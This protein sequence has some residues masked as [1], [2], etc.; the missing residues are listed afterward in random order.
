MVAQRELLGTHSSHI[1]GVDGR[2]VLSRP[3]DWKGLILERKE[4]PVRA[5]CGPQ[6]S[7]MP[8]VIVSR[9]SP[10]RRWYRCHGKTQEI[11]MVA[12]GVDT[13]GAAYERDYGRWECDPGGES[14]CLRLHPD[15]LR[16]YLQDEA[17]RFDLDTRY[18]VKDDTLVQAVFALAEEMQNQFP[19]GTLY[20]EGMS[21][22]IL[23]WL[24]RHHAIKAADTAPC[25][26]GL[27]AAQQAKVR[28]FVDTHLDFDLTVECMAAEAGISPFHF[29]RLF[30]ASFGMPPYRYVLQMRIARA[31]YLLRAEKGRTVADIALAVGFASQAHLTHAFK[32]Q[33][34]QT[35]GRWRVS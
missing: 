6:F 17:C 19:N 12:P 2:P 14:I 35:P 18:S 8:V 30:R 7:G 34:G 16:R 9:H 1:L 15:I 11:P 25:E 23:G 5:E 27:S 4:I 29:S 22:M 24:G 31:A 32:S 3:S 10:G 28:E 21:L 33:M 26:R 20:A 13:M